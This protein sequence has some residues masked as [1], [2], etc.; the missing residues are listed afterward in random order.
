MSKPSA[1]SCLPDS[2][3]AWIGCFRQRVQRDGKGL[4]PEQFGRLIG[5]SGATVRRW[6]SNSLYPDERDIARIADAACL[7]NQQAWFLSAAC[8]RMDATPPPDERDFK[9]YMTEVLSSTPYPAM[10]IDGLFYVRAWNSYV[11]VLSKGMSRALRQDL[12]AIAMMLRRYPEALF[13]P[14]N[15]Q[16]ALREGIRIFWVNTAIHSHR[17]EYAR[18]ISRLRDEPRFLELW[19]ELALGKETAPRQPITFAQSIAGSGAQYRVYSR[20]ISFPPTFYLHEYQPDDELACSRLAAAA[21]RGRARAH[22]GSRLHWV[23]LEAC[24]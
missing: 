21:D 4:S 15:H 23:D 5:R 11:D 10:V 13:R 7:T 12:H 18:L 8:T 3:G 2:P 24:C 9:A 20:T 22:F 19:M 6:E 1:F 17:P 16:D 14:E